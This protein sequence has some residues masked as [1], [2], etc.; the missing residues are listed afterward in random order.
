MNFMTKMQDQIRKDIKESNENLKGEIFK[1][2]KKIN[3]EVVIVKK[4]I[5]ELKTEN[6]TLKKHVD[7]NHAETSSRFARMEARMDS[8]DKEKEKLDIQKRK[9]EE[10]AKS[11]PSDNTGK[12]SNGRVRK[13]DDTVLGK[14]PEKYSDKVKMLTKEVDKLTV[15]K[16]EPLKFR[17][18]WAR[19][20]S[21]VSLEQ[22]LIKATEAAEK[23]ENEGDERKT[24]RRKGDSKPI[25]LGDSMDRHDPT[26]WPWETNEEEW[27]WNR[28]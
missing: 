21:Q 19:Q 9:R 6:E 15:E 28:G 7:D 14:A 23:L 27:G 2:M 1:G 24:T 12:H 4:K 25:L 10:L 5:D 16:V 20:M 18:S 3:G 26:D 13:E 11:R 22:Q 8:F 17:S